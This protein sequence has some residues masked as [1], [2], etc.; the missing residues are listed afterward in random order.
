MSAV[1]DVLGQAWLGSLFGAAGL[2]FGVYQ[3][4]RKHEPKLVYQYVGQRLIDDTPSV[5]SNAVSVFY[6]GEAVP[7][8]SIL[9]IILWNDG[10]LPIRGKDIVG[11]TGIFCTLSSDSRI[12]SVEISKST[13]SRNEFEVRTAQDC[14]N[15]MS[16][17]FSYLNPGDGVLISILHTGSNSFVCFDVAAVGM[18]NGIRSYGGIPLNYIYRTSRQSVSNTQ[19]S[20]SGVRRFLD[21]VVFNAWP[22]ASIATGILGVFLF[23][24]VNNSFR[25]VLYG[26]P[27]I[28]GRDEPLVDLFFLTIAIGYCVGG[29]VNIWKTRRRYPASLS[30]V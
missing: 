26:M 12:L 22:I 18:S 29:V 13:E 11:S 9:K 5:L 21:Y 24:F 17:K 15:A 3:L 25:G 30:P 16:F 20:T 27:P 10:N 7:R 4:Y 1:L 14:E 6:K 23:S 19:D 8:V 2:A 28:A